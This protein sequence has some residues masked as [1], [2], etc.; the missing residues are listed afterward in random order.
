MLKEKLTQL[1][2]T[3]IL[4][5]EKIKNKLAENKKSLKETQ[6]KMNETNHKLE[7]SLKENSEN[8]K[9]LELLL[10]EMEELLILL[11]FMNTLPPV[12]LA[13]ICTWRIMIL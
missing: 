8:E 1:N 5:K 9:V 13:G 3:F 6:T 7:L 11:M 4:L 12:I 2:N 10:K